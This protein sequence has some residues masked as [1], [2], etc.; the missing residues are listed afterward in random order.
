MQEMHAEI[1]IAP[2]TDPYCP[3]EH[4]WGALALAAHHEP[5]GQSWH[6]AELLAPVDGPNVPAEQFTGAVKPV[7]AQYV[8]DGHT[9]HRLADDAPRV[10]PKVPNGQKIARVAPSVS[11]YDPVGHTVQAL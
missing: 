7:W 9:R 10:A 8:P 4:A 11:Q 2:A 3:D 1:E 6:E 5:A